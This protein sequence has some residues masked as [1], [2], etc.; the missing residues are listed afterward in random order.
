M[1]KYIDFSSKN[2]NFSFL[3]GAFIMI[4]SHGIHVV[5][6]EYHLLFQISFVLGYILFIFSPLLLGKKINI[7]KLLYKGI[8]V[9]LVIIGIILDNIYIERVILNKDNKND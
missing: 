8:I 2:I 9:I 4:I 7:Y 1:N 6:P 5:E 3:I